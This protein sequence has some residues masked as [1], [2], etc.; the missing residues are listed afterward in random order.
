MNNNI[1]E[2]W[3]GKLANL[4]SFLVGYRRHFDLCG[5]Q[6]I[7]RMSSRNSEAGSTAVIS[8]L[9]RALVHAT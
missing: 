2:F 4:R 1:H 5:W 6:A 8:N 7:Y 9:S 3:L